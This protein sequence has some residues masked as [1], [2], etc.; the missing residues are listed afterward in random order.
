VVAGW[1]VGIGLGTYWGVTN[2][3]GLFSSTYNLNVFGW[4]VGAV[5]PGLAAFT[6][7]LIVVVVGSAVAVAVRGR[8]P[9]SGIRERDYL[10][11]VAT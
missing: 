5:Y 7:N 8:A 11:A 4:H 6:A 1:A 10:P 9:E 3:V 2:P